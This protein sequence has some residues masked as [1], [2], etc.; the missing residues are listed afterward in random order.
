MSHVLRPVKG[1]VPRPLWPALALAA[2]RGDEGAAS[3]VEGAELEAAGGA[4]EL[5]GAG[6]LV[7][8]D[9]EGVDVVRLVGFDELD[10]CD[11]AE[12]PPFAHVSGSTYC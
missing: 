4:G 5:D 8:L 6:E 10:G 9:D 3:A 7:E 2:A 11:P 12:P 1:S